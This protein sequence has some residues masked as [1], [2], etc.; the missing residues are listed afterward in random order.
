LSVLL[1]FPEDGP[2][3]AQNIQQKGI[4][5]NVWE[6]IAFQRAFSTPGKWGTQKK[7]LKKS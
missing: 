4:V 5:S 6:S 1:I 3:H 7:F 2:A